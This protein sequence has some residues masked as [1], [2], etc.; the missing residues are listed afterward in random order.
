MLP[1]PAAI[2]RFRILTGPGVRVDTGV[3]EGD[4]VPAEFDSMMAKII[5]YGR[6]RKEALV[7]SAAGAAAECGRHQ[8]RSQQQ[9]LSARSAEPSRG[10]ASNVIQDG[11]I[12]WLPAGNTWPGTYAD[13]ALVQAAI[14]AYSDELALEQQASS[15]RF[16]PARAAAGP[17]RR[18]PEARAALSRA[19]LLR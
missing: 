5:A 14:E 18:G 15:M 7:P 4:S 13:V 3:A 2:E 1:H 11:W 6:T 19:S 17:V 8:G 12:G 16:R 9:S 10:A